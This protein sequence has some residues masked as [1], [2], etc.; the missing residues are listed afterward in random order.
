VSTA[1][2]AVIAVLALFW[3]FLGCVGSA[4]TSGFVGEARQLAPQV[5]P[6]R[7]LSL[8][9]SRSGRSWMGATIGIFGLF[10]IAAGLFLILAYAG[11]VSTPGYVALLVGVGL[12]ILGVGEDALAGGRRMSGRGVVRL[13]LPRLRR[14]RILGVAAIAALIMVFL[15]GLAGVIAPEAHPSLSSVSTSDSGSDFHAL[16]QIHPAAIATTTIYLNRSQSSGTY[17]H[18]YVNLNNSTTLTAI[19][20]TLTVAAS[21]C[22]WVTVDNLTLAANPASVFH[23]VQYN[24]VTAANASGTVKAGTATTSFKACGGSAYWV[25]Y[26]YW[27]YSIYQFSTTTL[28]VNG[29]LT[30]GTFSDFP[31]TS[32]APKAI[33][34]NFSKNSEVSVKIPSNLTS[35]TVTFPSPVNGS[36]TCTYYGSC[37]YPQ[38]TYASAADGLNT[39]TSRSI[40]FSTASG[41]RVTAAY[42]NW[43][44]G[45]TVATLSSYSGAG[46]F[47]SQ[48]G[49][50]FE[51]WFVGVWYVWILVLLIV[52][53]IAAVV[54]GGKRRRRN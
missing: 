17:V 40:V 43:T 45:Y 20:A 6:R 48:T 18:E 10:I 2:A 49:N 27:T 37:T 31:G 24:N 3:G 41:L 32:A 29:T 46:L 8:R 25:N 33:T 19:P 51:E 54:S 35:F 12:V 47:F 9:R 22:K 1:A 52:I 26:V 36:S 39:S 4:A 11:V 34:A 28:L 13:G 38:Y 14:N 16:S 50:F 21:S 30:V 42:E 15:G 7:V 23:N 44:V 5:P 53:A